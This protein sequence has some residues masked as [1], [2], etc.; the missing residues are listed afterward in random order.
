MKKAVGLIRKE[1]QHKRGKGSTN[2]G[3]VTQM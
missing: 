2:V 1:Y 3:W